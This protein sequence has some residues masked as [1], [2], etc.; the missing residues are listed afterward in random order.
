MAQTK[1]PTTKSVGF[2]RGKPRLYFQSPHLHEVGFAPGQI[3]A[4]GLHFGG[5]IELHAQAEMKKGHRKVCKKV[6]G[7]KVFSIIDLN[8]YMPS[9]VGVRQ[10][11]LDWRHGS[12]SITPIK[13]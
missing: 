6:I 11:Q 12:V 7:D 8:H 4:V 1:F 3:Y 2:H 13:E 10:V 9:L 5:V